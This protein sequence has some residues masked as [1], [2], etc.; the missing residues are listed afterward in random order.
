MADLM[1]GTWEYE[2]L[3][4][5]YNNFMVPA[6]K[7]EVGGTDLIKK[8]LRIVSAEAVLSI[9]G[10]SS[11]SVTFTDC[12]DLKNGTFDKDLKAAAV[13]G[14]PVVMSL[15]YG[16]AFQKVFKGY[17]SNVRMTMS[18]TRGMLME[19][20]GLDARRLMMTDNNHIRE[21]KIKNYS[22]AVSELLKRYSK[23]ASPVVDA[24][25]E[26]MKDGLI[27]QNG[28][29]YDFIMKELIE[30]G[31]TQR[32][33]FIAVDKVYFRK[34][35]SVVAPVITLKPGQGLAGFESDA[36]Y[37]DESFHVL[38]YDAAKGETIE[39]KADA[40]TKWSS[41]AVLS[42][43]GEWYISDPACA[44]KNQAVNRAKALADRALTASQRAQIS[45]VGLPELIPG[46]FI[47]IDRVDS[48]VN[49]KYYIT[50]V[51]H[52]IDENGYTT[53]LTTEGWE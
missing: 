18:V 25:S 41:A 48:L 3:E 32:E 38:G 11:V 19:F 21:Y 29:D 43:K 22:D 40:K 33:F 30:S 27:W 26:N 51:V 12:Y 7:F 5:T 14:K 39:G 46:R 17:L 1:S 31:R 28:S 24:T 53:N 35:R 23:L 49:K 34:P 6:I 10:C 13:L 15:G 42:Q 4:K 52:K 37:V 44:A 36:G 16:S 2:K 50:Q 20:V 45:C 47:K 9:K 8:G